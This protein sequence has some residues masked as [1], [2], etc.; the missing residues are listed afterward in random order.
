MNRLFRIRRFNKKK[1][2]FDILFPQTVTQNV[3]RRD[4]GGVL[5]DY[6]VDYDK[7]IIN[8][9]LH[10][11]RAKSYG[12]NR[13]LEAHIRN[14]TL[15]NGFP[16]LLTTHTNVEC[17]PTLNFNNSGPK[18][19]LS[20][21]GDPIPGGQCEGTVMFL[22]YSEEKDAWTLLSS[23]TYSDITKVLMPIVREYTYVATHDDESLIVIPGFDAHTNMIDINYGQTILRAGLDY[24]FVKNAPNTIRLLNFSINTNEI[25]FCKITSYSVTAKRGSFKYVLDAE[26][27]PVTINENGVDTLEI[28]QPAIGTNY[29][30]INYGQTIMRNGLDYEITED[31]EHVK[32]KFPLYKNDVIVFRSIKMI[33][34]NGDIV[35]NNWGAT[36]NYRYNLNV[37]HEEYIAT[38]D[39]IT[40]I[41][42]PNYNRRKDELTVIRNNHMLVYDVD[43]TVDTLDQVVLLTSHLDTNDA[44]Y[45]TIL[46]GAMMDV[47]NFNVINASGDSA[48][49]I[50]ADMSYGLL[51]DFYTLL[52]KLKYDLDS[53]PTLKCIDGP[54]EPICDPFGNPVI[55]GYK[56]GAYLWLVYNEKQH[57]WYSLSH[58]SLDVTATYPTF[59]VAEGDARFFGNQPLDITYGDD[60]NMIGETVIKHGLGMIP[61]DI[62]IRPIEPPGIDPDTKERQSIGDVWSRA[63]KENLYVGNSGNATSLF[64]W[65]VSTQ[66]QNTDLRTYLDNAIRELK[67]RPGNFVT[68]LAAV[69]IADRGVTRVEVPDFNPDTDK[70]FMV[71]YGQTVLRENEDYVV[72]GGAIELYYI[73]FNP[74]DVV[75]FMILIQAPKDED[76]G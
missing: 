32:F 10:L 14:K 16:L 3:L 6:L 7:H 69:T 29:L 70:I 5:E 41:P 75:Q 37:L 57:V 71:N 15:Y 8:G 45:F 36:G 25:L 21:S 11:N 62:T 56:A 39:N 22:I 30:E 73:N 49:H 64:H 42:V 65:V 43:Y 61:A 58:G 26:D 20:G 34:T 63:D 50:H 53:A 47:P 23:D 67:K 19:I 40:V 35:P 55:G 13:H 76:E 38:E 51:V 54:A 72:D 59:K 2:I 46:Q 18:P 4:D 60:P 24:E 31:A 52:V 48:Q 66:T 12:T 9:L 33:E 44:I 27:F 17:E 74:G 1:G 28:P 68:R